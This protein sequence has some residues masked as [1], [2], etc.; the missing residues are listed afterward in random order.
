MSD[1]T[2]HFAA[3]MLSHIMGRYSMEAAHEQVHFPSAEH[4]TS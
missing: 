2:Q 1:I 4:G 3:C